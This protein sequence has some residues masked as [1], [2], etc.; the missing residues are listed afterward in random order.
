MRDKIRFFSEVFHTNFA[1][2]SY[3]L[4]KFDKFA[5]ISSISPPFWINSIQIFQNPFF[6][7]QKNPLS[8][9][10]EGCQ[11]TIFILILVLFEPS[12]LP[13]QSV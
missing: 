9:R 12:L 3:L 6:Y 4:H 5:Q 8:E 7:I 1:R 2:Q 13:L 11:Y 10:Q